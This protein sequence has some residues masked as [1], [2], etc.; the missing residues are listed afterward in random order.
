MPTL[1]P[2]PFDE[3]TDT[4][5]PLTPPPFYADGLKDAVAPLTPPA[6]D[7]AKPTEQPLTPPAFEDAK[8]TTPPVTAE[9]V[10]KEAEGKKNL[11]NYLL[12]KE[13][14]VKLHPELDDAGIM[15]K[16]AEFQKAYD[17][18][19][20]LEESAKPLFPIYKAKGDGVGA[21]IERGA[22]NL[23]EGLETPQNIM[24]M[25]ALGGA[26]AVLQKIAAAGF[27][28]D[29]AS[30]VP[31]QVAKI[32]E[33]TTP[34]GK[35]EAATEAAGSGLMALAAGAH[36][37]GVPIFGRPGKGGQLTAEDLQAAGMPATAEAVKAANAKRL[38]LAEPAQVA[39]VPIASDPV[40]DTGAVSTAPAPV[41]AA[42]DKVV[43][44]LQKWR[45]ATD[46]AEK[47]RLW[48]EAKKMQV[49]EPEPTGEAPPLEP[50]DVVEAPAV[51][52]E[53]PAG[54][55]A[56]E[57]APEPV[58]T[59]P[60]TTA[61]VKAIDDAL[62]T[63][64]KELDVLA[65]GDV[66]QTIDFKRPGG[67]KV[68][69]QNTQEALGA[70]RGRT[71][72][73][74]PPVTAEGAP[75]KRSWQAAVRLSDGRVF[76]MD[77]HSGVYERMAKEG[78]TEKGER[79]YM[80]S[81]GTWAKSPMDIARLENPALAPKPAEPVP[82][83]EPPADKTAAKTVGEKPAAVAPAKIGSVDSVIQD[84]VAEHGSLA[85]AGEALDKRFHDPAT[86]EAHKPVLMRALRKLNSIAEAEYRREA[87]SAHDED[88]GRSKYELI[89][90]VKRLGGLPT[91]KEKGQEATGELGRIIETKKGAFLSLFRKGAKSLD[92][93]RLALSE[94]GF[95]FET[96]YDMLTAI[97]DSMTN[98]RKY[99]GERDTSGMPQG[100]GKM[101]V[102]EL[103]PQRTTGLKKAVVDDERIQRG[104][105]DLP[106]AEREPEEARVQRAEDRVDADPTVA[107]KIVE[108]I[109]DK[110]ETAIS[111][112]DA[113]TLLVERT[114]LM[115]ERQMTEE[116]LGEWEDV[117]ANT[118]KLDA[119]EKQIERL[120]RAQRIAGSSW[121]RVGHLYQRMMRADFS[122]EAMQMRARAAKG[123]P[124]DAGEH[125]TIKKQ[126]A[127]IADLLKKADASAEAVRQAGEIAE[128]NRILEATLRELQAGDLGKPS[129]HPKVFEAARRHVEAAKKRADE[130]RV[131]LRQRFSQLNAG[132]DPGVIRDVAE[133]L[134]A[135]VAEFALDKSEAFSSVIA[136]FGEDARP[137]LEKAWDM[138]GKMLDKGDVGKAVKTRSKKGE[139]TQV[140]V[141]ARAKAEATAGEPL[142]KKTVY[143]LARAAINEGVHGEDAIMARVH[144]DVKEFYPAATERDVRRALVDYGKAKFPNREAV[145]TE[146]R[147][148][149]TLVRL[150]ESIDRETE[151][152]DSL[153][154]GLQRDKATQAIRDKQKQLNE[155][156]KKRA[157]TPSPEK[158]AS[159]DAAR[160][161]AL[162][163]SIEDLDRQL[164]TGDPAATRGP[165]LPDSPEV[166][167][168]KAE[169][170]AM[171]AKLAEIEAEKNPGPTPAE[172]QMDALS[173]VRER[174]DELLRGDR[175]PAKRADF[176][177]LSP[178]AEAMHAEIGAM[179]ELAAQMRRDAKPKA[180]PDA[181][182]EA[183]K[184]KALEDAIERYRAKTAADDFSG[185]D[186]R[187]GPDT[188][189]V[190]A[191]KEVLASR[192]SMYEAAKKAGKPVLTPEQRYNALRSKQIA[193]R[194]A[195]LD[196]RLKESDFE[197]K[198]KKVQPALNAENQANQ[199]AV[200]KK[201]REFKKQELAWRRARR[202]TFEKVTNW[203][204]NFAR[205]NVLGHISVL[206]HLAGAA[207]ENI[208]TRPVGSAVAQL[209]RLNKTLEA[210]RKKA[211]YEGGLGG[212]MAGAR[213]TLASMK[214]VIQ[215]LTKGKSDIDW[216]HDKGKV[217]PHEFMEWVGNVHGAIKE[218]VR[219]GIYARSM[220]LGIKAAEEKGLNP[221]ADPVLY[222]AISKEAY[223]NANMDIFIGDN[224]L[225]KAIHNNVGAYLRGEKGDP[226]L[227]RFT[228]DVLDILFPIV[229]V[230]V[231][232][233]IRK[234]RLAAGLPEFAARLASHAAK[235][236]LANGADKLT[237][238]DA[239]QITRAF[240]YGVTGAALAA[241][242]WTHANQ[243]GGI[244]AP[245]QQ[246]PRDKST[247]L[248]PGE[249]AVPEWLSKLT[250]A[251]HISHHVLHGPWGGH[252][253]MVADARRMYDA[254]VAKGDSTFGAMS[255]SAF[256]G[257]FA[258]A[259][260]LP[261]FS[262]IGRITSPYQSAGQKAA[263]II[264][265][266]FLFGAVQDIAEAMDTHQRKAKTFEDEMKL[267]IPGVR[268]SL[269]AKP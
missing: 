99:Y 169:R 40:T 107:A 239:E 193:A 33:A 189:R 25:G 194:M 253:N 112:D 263:Q 105:E 245:G 82:A 223:D 46:P 3:A 209:F 23:A 135:K 200:E 130:A 98:G 27:A 175:E 92:D 185:P 104:L 247:G 236:D 146:L 179:R 147:E 145:A 206:E 143:E 79:G 214:A 187:Q 49:G 249:A 13:Q 184:I 68:T 198:A 207:V 74:A 211:V 119:I 180:D 144:S 269:P 10:D 196:R 63:A 268:E 159:R 37:A 83:V 238:R 248:K 21:G 61:Y 44:T 170:D 229:N 20:P 124:L 201:L 132:A 8:D 97:E 19:H 204:S 139:K 43:S 67:G 120:D 160:Q 251:D 58:A 230:P 178:A 148:L 190:A 240:K 126:A 87:Q 171:K 264:K 59:D 164:R 48:D 163:N 202:G 220:E 90:E 123:G 260:D 117:E 116:R 149:G 173:K 22:A 16:R 136:E 42:V 150:Q 195:E 2:P 167:R 108:R 93:L 76:T 28:V 91:L 57:S 191:L 261:A 158:L 72:P 7:E 234:F 212:E 205:V 24:L 109:V 41:A 69:V 252:M 154:T 128:Q 257:M 65:K 199:V 115:N 208:V 232:I 114:R 26:P 122:L 227:A 51:A 39:P 197:P 224:F 133:I 217:Y 235:G 106:P 155:L 29:M 111:P 38:S 174:M 55:S 141:K 153:H 210:I 50:P 140:D 9:P 96:P 18:N 47:A 75:V 222:K 86:P 243:F 62:A 94:V 103:P 165:G 166:E 127:E 157:G 266:I 14:L 78:I 102:G 176:K 256:F 177:P 17:E 5:Q 100:P 4:A 11:S 110:G 125:E 172:Q 162:R 151:G 85:S 1:Q 31:L 142:S 81:D 218:P 54:A 12:T 244:Y 88:L 6:F 137:F 250:G 121:G 254:R 233:A 32:S 53:P 246:A 168:L 118:D 34:G 182:A 262:T 181:K 84:A 56:P 15:A 89:S 80:A 267:A 101:T 71:A 219:Q 73:K 255:E 77:S 30:H 129:Y 66:P 138:V 45:A 228:A 70:L 161:T 113:A 203:V 215:K 131:R 183:A 241:Y 225:T 186:K 60:E 64:P 213:A 216:L 221:S 259:K 52:N 242:A 95:D 156:L 226:G 231:N 258:G 188:A 237:P 152:L 134:Y 265:N 36:A 35:A 192:K